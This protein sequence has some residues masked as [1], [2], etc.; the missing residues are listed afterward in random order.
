MLTFEEKMKKDE[1][2]KKKYDVSELWSWSRYKCYKDD[3]WEF[4]LNYVAKI[5]PDNES[6]TMYL[7][8][9]ET[10]HEIL[11]KFV[12]DSSYTNKQMVKDFDDKVLECEIEGCR[13][14][15]GN[16]E[17]NE[18]LQASYVNSIQ[19]MLLNRKLDFSRKSILTEQFIYCKIGK[20]VFRGYADLIIK[21]NGYVIICDYK[22]STIYSDKQIKELKGQLFIYAKA[23]HDT[24]KIPYSRIKIGWDFLKYVQVDMSLKLGKEKRR[25]IERRMIGGSLSSNVKTWLNDKNLNSKYHYTPEQKNEYLVSL[26]AYNTLDVLPNE[27]KSK[28]KIHNDCFV[29][30][31]YTEDEIN[32]FCK[33]VETTLN[34][35]KEKTKEWKETKDSS[36]FMWEVQSKDE[37]RLTQLGKYSRNLHKP[38]DIYLKEKEKKEFD[39]NYISQDDIDKIR[40]NDGL[41]DLLNEVLGNDS[42]KKEDV[43][44]DFFNE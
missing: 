14:V 2:L 28:F 16:E 11:E 7:R 24:Y 25:N 12:K 29:E 20:Y 31:E 27:I 17:R 30:C 37:F 43:N 5:E 15:Y 44:D 38:L 26:V 34:E 39:K 35:I 8:L 42:N 4:F 41:D 19:H 33:E 22:T 1:M 10:V 23:I 9:G 3:S 6:E 21:S 40:N 36:M 13:F 32:D 18:T